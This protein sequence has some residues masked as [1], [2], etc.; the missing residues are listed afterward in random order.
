MPTNDQRWL[1]F[2]ALA[3]NASWRRGGYY[4]SWHIVPPATWRALIHVLVVFIASQKECLAFPNCNPL[5]A[6]PLPKL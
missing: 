5:E 6:T 1:G 3:K 2:W 4:N